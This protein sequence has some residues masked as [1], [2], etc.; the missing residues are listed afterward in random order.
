M[1]HRAR[2]STAVHWG[3]CWIEIPAQCR[4]ADLVAILRRNRHRMR[5]N[6]RLR[7]LEVVAR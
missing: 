5:W 2:S 6:P 3:A 4:L 1:S 7:A